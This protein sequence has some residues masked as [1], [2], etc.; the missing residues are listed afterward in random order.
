MTTG[1]INQVTTFG[2]GARP[3]P[4]E[5]GGKRGE[6]SGTGPAEGAGRS[7]HGRRGAWRERPASRAPAHGRSGAPLGRGEHSIAPTEVLRRRSATE[8]GLRRS[9]RPTAASAALKEDTG[10]RHA[11][12]AAAPGAGLPPGV[13]RE[14]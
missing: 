10:P 4:P 5:G 9:A 1:R 7:P 14:C 12:A 6:A 8:A 11:D 3:L 2:P 13:L